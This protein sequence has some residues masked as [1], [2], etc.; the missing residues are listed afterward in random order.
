MSMSPE[1]PL[2]S[3]RSNVYVPGVGMSMSPEF[4]CPPRECLC[5]RSSDVPGVPMSPEFEFLGMSMSPE[6]H[7]P[8]VPPE[9]ECLC[10]RS[11]PSPESP[12]NVYVPGVP[13]GVP[14]PRSPPG[15]SMSP[16]F[17]P[18]VPPRS[19]YVPGVRFLQISSKHRDSVTRSMLNRNTNTVV[20]MNA[21]VTPVR[22]IRM[23]PRYVAAKS[24]RARRRR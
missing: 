23:R 3:G 2:E 1:S 22:V 7:V 11:P 9:F 15:M 4:L 14:R 13:P 6:F 16:E 12:G 20:G 8:G 18:G 24:S 5:P 10:P 19:S 17:L 21:T